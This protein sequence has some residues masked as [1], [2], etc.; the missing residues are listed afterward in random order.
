MPCVGVKYVRLML[1]IQNKGRGLNSFI[2]FYSLYGRVF[3]RTIILYVFESQEFLKSFTALWHSN[4]I[5]NSSK[6]VMI[7]R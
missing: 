7:L 4:P 1:T 6:N 3:Q 2:K 5:N